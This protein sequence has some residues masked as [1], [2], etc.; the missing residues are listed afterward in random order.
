MNN[1]SPHPISWQRRVAAWLVHLFTASGAVFGL[2]TLIA[3]YQ[4]RFSLA[5]WL[6]A[7]AIAVD[8]VDGLFARLAQ[9]K[10]AVP[11]IDGALLDNI[12]DY[13]NYVLTPAFFL[14]VSNLVPSYGGFIGASAI[15]LTS[16]FQFSQTE[17]KTDD[18]F[19]KGFPSYWNIIIFYLFILQMPSAANLAIILFL[20]VMIFVPIKYVYP[21]RPDNL[22]SK[23]WLRWVVIIVSL[24]WG[25]AGIVLLWTYP[26]TNRFWMAYSIGFCIFYFLF[27]LYR[28]IFPLQIGQEK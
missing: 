20:A 26:E 18:H 1:N 4:Q 19:F 24:L 2:L 23:V 11:Q 14:I 16:A 13:V 25:V 15:V 17:A 10:V 21:S 5:F 3:I 22:T 12:L 7:G 6:M 28:T 27:S 9:T 8:S